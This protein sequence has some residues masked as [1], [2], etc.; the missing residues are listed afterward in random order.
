MKL[1]HNYAWSLP[2]TLLGMGPGVSRIEVGD[3][4][5][6]VT[7]GWAFR[8]HADAAHV[9]SVEIPDKRLPLLAGLG[10]H[11]WAGGWAVNAARQPYAIV[12]FDPPQPARVVGFP[13][14]VRKLHLCPSDPL[15]LK[16]ELEA[17][18]R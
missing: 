9:V 2:M 4:K 6:D 13:V 5:L 18:S 3:G 15:M 16:Q 11:G 8:M 17:F 14:R 1:Q 7:M 12:S 10:V